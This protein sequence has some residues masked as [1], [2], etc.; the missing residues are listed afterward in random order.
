M[1]LSQSRGFEAVSLLLEAIADVPALADLP[2][3]RNPR[4]PSHLGGG[5]RILIVSEVSDVNVQKAGARET[6]R[7]LVKIGVLSRVDGADADADGLYC[8]LSDTVQAALRP[9]QLAATITKHSE[10]NVQFYVDDIDVDGAVV[11]GSWE[12]DYT[13]IRP[14]TP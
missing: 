14:G 5:E 11:I 4:R 12:I 10:G 13:R 2:I 3:V 1:S 6:R 7:R 8:L 9:M